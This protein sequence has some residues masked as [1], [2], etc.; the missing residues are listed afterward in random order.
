MCLV[1]RDASSLRSLWHPALNRQM[2]HLLTFFHSFKS[3]G[4]HLLDAIET[5]AAKRGQHDGADSTAFPKADIAA[6]CMAID[7][8]FRHQR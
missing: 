4:K 3:G 2:N 5:A 7:G 8:H 1:L 6:A